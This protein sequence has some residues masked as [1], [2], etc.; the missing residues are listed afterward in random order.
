VSPLNRLDQR[1]KA[2]AIAHWKTSTSRVWFIILHSINI[3][4]EDRMSA[5]GFVMMKAY[6]FPARAPSLSLPSPDKQVHEMPR[7]FIITPSYG[8]Q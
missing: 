2:V 1:D 5:S 7:R 3:F 4:N 6:G 8:T